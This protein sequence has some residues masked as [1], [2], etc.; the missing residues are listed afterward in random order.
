[1][2]DD[3]KGQLL[4]IR[5]E[6]LNLHERMAEQTFTSH[7]TKDHEARIRDLESFMNKFKGAVVIAAFVGG[8][9]SGAISVAVQLLMN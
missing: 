4:D 5:Q 6:L 2:S 1:M 9:I 8:T 7:Q 3:M